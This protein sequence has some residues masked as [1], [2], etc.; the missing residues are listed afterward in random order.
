[1]AD[2]PCAGQSNPTKY[3]P[4]PAY[5]TAGE[6]LFKNYLTTV[7]YGGNGAYVPVK[8]PDLSKLPTD[9]LKITDDINVYTEEKAYPVIR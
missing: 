5:L 9:G 7:A 6:H 4:R 3:P 8:A 2:S 1:M